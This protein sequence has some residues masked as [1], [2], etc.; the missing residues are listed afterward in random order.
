MIQ[1]RKRITVVTIGLVVGTVLV[2][3]VAVFFVASSSFRSNLDDSILQLARTEIA[4]ATDTGHLHVH[5]T[6]P[7][8]LKVAGVAGYEKYVWIENEAGSRLAATSNI[9]PETEVVGVDPFLEVAKRGF[10]VFGDI[11]VDGKAVRAVF[12]PFKDLQGKPVY[13]VVGIPSG[14]I[15]TTVE[16]MGAVVLGVGL[17]AMLIGIAVALLLS[18]YVTDPLRELA[19]GVESADPSKGA[20]AEIE[21]PYEEVST[22][23]NAFNQMVA[24]VRAMLAE[25]EATIDTQRRFVADTSHELRTPVSN[26]R[27]VLDVTLRRDR[28]ADEYRE[29]L[30]TADREVAR[31][32]RLVQ[33]LLDLAK[34]DSG[35]LK[36]VMHPC[37]AAAIV[38]AAAGAKVE[39]RVSI[40]VMAPVPV[41]VEADEH[42]VRQA[43]DNL[44]R[45]ALT[46]AKSQVEVS[47]T[48]SEGDVRIE[49]GNDG[50]PIPEAELDAI[51]ERFYRL[52]ASRARDTGGSGL[53][54]SIVR[55]IATG[56]GG[57]VEVA[58]SEAWTCFTLILPALR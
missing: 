2:C 40:S 15:T 25:R 58:S 50:P 19:K 3:A 26:L 16:K 12:Y 33:D 43:I 36:F 46:H 37:D 32:G 22:L 48:C 30:E 55:A 20:V 47:A 42:R 6:S 21:A 23:A 39:P 8:T 56:H 9:V 10:T 18:R 45:N 4:S 31:M 35:E 41:M 44:L 24:R 51:F 49:V 28:T 53:G 14:A 29:A 38:K 7:R 5:E 27:N 52:D 54:L 17:V 13:G 1:L 34:S 57:R 11:Q